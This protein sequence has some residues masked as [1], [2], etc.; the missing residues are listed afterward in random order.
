MNEES[1]AWLL[2]EYIADRVSPEER[3]RVEEALQQQPD[4]RRLYVDLINLDVGLAQVSEA[5]WIQNMEQTSESRIAT[6]S[7]LRAGWFGVAAGVA[8]GICTGIVLSAS[9]VWAFSGPKPAARAEALPL[10]NPD[11]EEG[12]APGADGVPS[13]PRVWGGDYAAFAG[14]EN[15][16]TPASGARMLKFLRADNRLTPPD[17]RPAAGEIWQL[18]DLGTLPSFAATVRHVEVSVRFNSAKG[19][20]DEH[21]TFG[22][23][24]HA[25]RG[26]VRDGPALW[27]NHRTL[28]L[29]AASKE[30]LADE[31]TGS[32]QTLSTRLELPREATVLLIGLRVARKGV[33]TEDPEFQAHYVD[34]VQLHLVE[35]TTHKALF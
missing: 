17:S 12:S 13:V 34:Q 16:V 21:V 3:L 7:P 9:M 29:A 22:V 19:G 30:E 26:D 31:D 24:L 23:S 15:G 33:K 20:K 14:P 10:A 8:V 32:W 27:R 35:P 18:L 11:F 1:W 4:V 25:F 2:S 5:V 28:A 6:P